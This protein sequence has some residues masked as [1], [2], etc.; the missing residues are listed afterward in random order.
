MG[1]A[2]FPMN[3]SGTFAHRWSGRRNVL[4]GTTGLWL[5][6]IISPQGATKATELATATFASGNPI[7]LEYVFEQLK[8]AGVA[9]V[10]P[11]VADGVNAV[12]VSY[13]PER[14]SFVELL[15]NYWKHCLPTQADGQFEEKGLDNAPVV[16]T[17]SAEEAEVARQQKDQLGQSEIFG[18]KAPIVVKIVNDT[19]AFAASGA[20]STLSA[21]KKSDP[22]KFK[23]VMKVRQKYF[24]QHFGFVQYCKDNVCGYVRFAPKC[25]GTCEAVFPEYLETNFGQPELD[26]NIKFTGGTF[27]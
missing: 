14:I 4:N 15:R 7:F 9:K 10:E 25:K 27:K 5:C 16:W 19:P 12:Q 23:K 3:P 8:Y 26:G 13:Q 18:V 22:K 24:D 11:G 2:H 17:S 20:T 1:F 21:L 6:E